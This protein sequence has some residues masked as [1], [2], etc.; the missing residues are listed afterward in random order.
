MDKQTAISQAMGRAKINLTRLSE[1][2]NISRPTLCKKLQRPN[3]IT[4]GELERMDK[5]LH[6]TEEET[7]VLIKGE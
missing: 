6:F 3:L 2:T 5:E 7:K 4:L 1:R